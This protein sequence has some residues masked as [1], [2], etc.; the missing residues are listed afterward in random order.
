MCTAKTLIGF[1]FA[2]VKRH[3]WWRSLI[4]YDSESLAAANCYQFV[5][6]WGYQAAAKRSL[7]F[8]GESEG[9]GLEASPRSST[10]SLSWTSSEPSFISQQLQSWHGPPLY[11]DKYQLQAWLRRSA[12]RPGSGGILCI[13]FPDS[14]HRWGCV[15][16]RPCLSSS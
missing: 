13:E 3:I 8:H 4:Y 11:S 2:D 5:L 1:F 6:K 9:H 7:A 10:A 12:E 16:A 15:T 14:Q